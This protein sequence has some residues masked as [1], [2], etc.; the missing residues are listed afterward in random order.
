MCQVFD[1]TSKYR[2][3]IIG[4]K[5]DNPELQKTV[6]TYVDTAYQCIKQMVTEICENPNDF[7]KFAYELRKYDYNDI[8]THDL[9]QHLDIG[10][11]CQILLQN[12]WDNFRQSMVVD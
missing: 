7:Y 5:L 1:I 12:K 8:Y 4:Q 6:D 2:N 9:L 3:G 10:P 11:L